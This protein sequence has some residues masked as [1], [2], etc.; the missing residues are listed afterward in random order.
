MRMPSMSKGKEMKKTKELPELQRV[1]KR[2]TELVG[3]NEEMRIQLENT[4]TD[5]TLLLNLAGIFF[6]ISMVFGISLKN[7]DDKFNE[8]NSRANYYE[9][10]EQIEKAAYRTESLCKNLA[11]V[12]GREFSAR[13]DGYC[14]DSKI[15]FYTD[16]QIIDAISHYALIKSD[17]K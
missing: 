12:S 17:K 16:R 3:I 8:R 1:L 11:E 5:R 4:Q 10:E 6:I 9:R 14:Q 2:N 13:Y 7:M 15:G